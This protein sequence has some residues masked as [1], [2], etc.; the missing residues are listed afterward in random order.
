M[1]TTWTVALLSS[2]ISLINEDKFRGDSGDIEW[3]R[4]TR[5]ELRTY[6]T[7]LYNRCHTVL[8]AWPSEMPAAAYFDFA[9]RAIEPSFLACILRLATLS[10]ASSARQIF[11]RLDPPR[12]LLESLARIAVVT[13]IECKQFDLCIYVCLYSSWRWYNSSVRARFNNGM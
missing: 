12:C 11:H 3:G 2:G 13:S 10:I 9:R 1:S 8:L 4:P 5:I 7:S 6:G